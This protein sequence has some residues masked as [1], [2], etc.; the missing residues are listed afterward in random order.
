MKNNNKRVKLVAI[1]VAM[2]L[3]AQC[4]MADGTAIPISDWSSLN[5]ALKQSTAVDYIQLGDNITAGDSIKLGS[6]YS[7]DITFD[8]NGHSLTSSVNN[9]VWDIQSAT[10]LTIKNTTIENITSK[11][12]GGSIYNEG[13]LVAEN[14]TFSNNKASSYFGGAVANMADATFNGSMTFRGNSSAYSEN[15]FGGALLNIGVINFNTG[16]GEV[17]DFNG[18]YASYGGAIYNG[19]GL[20]VV[21]D[22]KFE[23]NTGR[24]EFNKN[25]TYRFENNNAIMGGAIYNAGRMTIAGNVTFKNNKALATVVGANNQRKGGGALYNDAG[26]LTLNGTRDDDGNASIVFEGNSAGPGTTPSDNSQH[27]GGALYVEGKDDSPAY[28]NIISTDFKNNTTTT[29]GGAIYFDKRVDFNIEDSRFIQNGLVG[30]NISYDGWGGAIGLGSGDIKGFI[31]NSVFQE[32]FSSSSGGVIASNTALT[33]VNS[34]FIGNTA[35]N[36]AGAISWDPHYGADGKY[37]KII[38]DGGDTFFGGNKVTG[39]STPAGTT[40][41]SQEGLYIGNY[42]TADTTGPDG[43]DSKVFFNAGN[44]G[45]LIFN[46]V[47]NAK[48][49]YYEDKLDKFKNEKINYNIQLN[50]SDVEYGRLEAESSNSIPNSAPTDGMIIFNNTVKGANLVLHNGTLAFHKEN[51]LDGYVGDNLE[52]YFSDGAKITLKGGTLDLSN[53]IIEGSDNHKKNRF[54]PDSIDVLGNANLRLDV[55]LGNGTGSIDYIDSTIQSSNGQGKLVIDKLLFNTDMPSSANLG[56]SFTLQFVKENKLGLDDITLANSLQTII[57]SH[58]GYSLKLDQ[59]GRKEDETLTEKNALKVT[60]VVS[61]GGLPVAVSIG[62]DEALAGEKTYV[63]NATDDEVIGLPPTSPDEENKSWYKGYQVKTENM[64]VAEDRYTSNILKGEFLEINGNGKNVIAA[65]D[66]IVGMVLDVDTYY[67]ESINIQNQKLII[68]D[69]KKSDGT[70]WNGFNTAIINKGGTVNLNNSIFSENHSTG[71]AYNDVS[72]KENGNVIAG[73]PYSKDGNGGAIQNLNR[74]KDGTTITSGELNVTNTSFTNNTATGDGGAIY[75][76]DGATT[77][78]TATGSNTVEFTGNKAGGV[79]NDIYNAG[80]LNLVTSA[81]GKIVFNGGISG[82]NGVM[83]IGT[84]AQNLGSVVMNGTIADQ[85]VNLNSGTLQI[86]TVANAF[87]NSNLTFNGGT[88]NSQNG[89]I[90]NMVVGNLN[91]NSNSN[92]LFDID[93]S[94]DNLS[95]NIQFTTKEGDGTLNVGTLYITGTLSDGTTSY[96]S[97]FLRGTDA[98]KIKTDYKGAGTTAVGDTAYSIEVRNNKVLISKVGASGGFVYDVVDENMG[99]HQVS[100]ADNGKIGDWIPGVG[101]Q[102]RGNIFRIYG[103]GADTDIIKSEKNILGIEVGLDEVQEQSQRLTIEDV[104]SYGGFNSAVINRGGEVF[105]NGVNFVENNASEK[106]GNLGYGGAIYNDHGVVNIGVSTSGATTFQKNNATR[107]GGAIYNNDELDI[108]TALAGNTILFT[109]NKA[110]GVANDIY[111][112]ETGKINIFGAGSVQFDSGIAGIGYIESSAN[113][114]LNS[115]NSKFGGRFAQTSGTTTVT[116]GAKFFDGQSTISGGQLNWNTKEDLSKGSLIV[117][118]GA[119]LIVGDGSNEAQLSIKGSSDITNADVTINNNANLSLVNK[120]MTIGNISGNGTLTADNSTLIYDQNSGVTKGFASINN[121]TVTVN[122][123]ENSNVDSIIGAIVNGSNVGLTLNFEDLTTSKDITLNLISEEAGADISNLNTS[124]D[125][126]I[127]GKLT[128]NA[129]I[130]TNSGTLT[131]SGTTENNYELV[132]NTN[133]TLNIDGIFTGKQTATITNNGT[134]NVT[135]DASGFGGKLD[136]YGDVIVE[137]SSYLFGGEK[138][139]HTGTLTINAGSI[140][141]RDVVLGSDA[142]GAKLI[143]TIS[144]NST[145]NKIDDSVFKFADGTLG[146]E[147]SFKSAS[148]TTANIELS[149]VDNGQENTISID[150]ANVTL[151]DKDYTGGTIYN[152]DNSNIKLGSD[153][154][155]V[156]DYKFSNV[157]GSDN[158]LSFNVIIADVAGAT[159]GSKYL[160][161]D[162]ITIGNGGQSFKFG[163][164]YISGEE[165]GWDGIYS[166]KDGDVLTGATFSDN[167]ASN[168]QDGKVDKLATGA[169]TSWIYDISKTN[170][171][172]SIQ[173]KI[174]SAADENTLYKMNHKT[175]G[176]RFFQFSDDGSNKEQTY[177]I[178]QSLDE[179][180][181]GDFTVKGYDK[182]KCTISGAF[183]DKTTGQETGRGSFFDI[184]KDD[185][186]LTIH[187]VTLANASKA[188]SGSV[189]N[190]ESTVSKVTIDNVNIISSSSSTDGGAIYNNG[191]LNISNT[192]FT[193]NS[194]GTQKGGAIYNDGTMNL[195][196]VTLDAP[197]ENATNDIYQ[198]ANGKTYFVGGENTINSSISGEGTIENTNSKLVLNG[199]NSKYT[200]TYT[201]N[202]GQTDVNEGS[203]FFG[204]ETTITNGVLNWNTMNDYDGVIKAEGG[205][206]NIGNNNDAELTLNTGSVVKKDAFVNIAKAGSIYLNGGSLTLDDKDKWQGDIFIGDENTVGS[207]TLTIDGLTSNGTIAANG[208]TIDIISGRLTASAGDMIKEATTVKIKDDALLTVSGGDVTLGTTTDWASKGGV[209]LTDGT[210]T[211]KDFTSS[212]GIFQATNG[213]LNIIENSTFTVGKDSFINSDVE[214]NIDSNSNL[215]ITDNGKVNINDNDTW[216]GTISLDGGTLNYGMTANGNT[217]NN[218]TLNAKTG[219]LNLLDGSYMDIQTPSKIESAVAVDIQRGATINIRNGAELNLDSNDRW[220]GLITNE[221]SGVLKTDNVDNSTYGGMLQQNRGTSIFDNNSNIYIDGKDSYIRGGTLGITNGSTLHVGSG[222]TDNH[223]FVSD[224]N[225]TNNSTLSAMNG[226][227]NRYQITN[228]M[229]VEGKNNVSIDIDGRNKVGDTFIINNLT[230]N[231]NGTLNVSDFNF[232][233]LAPID[234]QF[235]IRVFDSNSIADTVDFSSTNKE[236]LTPIGY[237]NLQSAGG[238]WYTSNMTRYNPQVFRGQVATLASFNNQLMIDDMLLNHVTLDS[239]R[240]LAQGKNANTYASTLPQFAPYQYK[241]EDGGLWY[242]SYVNFENLSLTQG[243]KVGNNSYGSLVGADFPI[244]KL[245]HGWRLMPTAYIGYNG[246][247]QTFNGV[248]MYQNGGQGGLMGTFMK[249]DFIGSIVAYGGGYNNE[250][251]VE[252]NT[253]RTGNW[254]AGTAAKLAYNFHP[255]KHFTIQPTAFMSYNIFGRQNWGT[256]FGSMSMNS[257]LL[258]GINVAPGMNFIYARETWSVYATFQYMYN[259]NEQVGGR[260]GNVDLAS[261]KMEHGYIQYGV[262]VTKTWKDRLNSFFQIVF[263]NGGRTGVGFQLGLNYT[264]DWFN[265]KSNKAPKANAKQIKKSSTSNKKSQEIKEFQHVGSKTVLKSLSMK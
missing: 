103:K 210:L 49:D 140:E 175:E 154:T 9:V 181:S 229:T 84:S 245:K 71:G 75:N 153:N 102:L 183:V 44:S 68:N 83:N 69:V 126:T 234:R 112:T 256:D 243:L 39:G 150:G 135:K 211:V 190:N 244:I 98:D 149:K 251:S 193:G 82:N 163:D 264:F 200:G 50:S 18:N 81:D 172:Q 21:K 199:D 208:G 213:E 4:A 167:P 119:K 136:S 220:A 41:P 58:A 151:V 32:N 125:V 155:T 37:L 3:S 182:D 222:V 60:K 207:G 197:T 55:T 259:I 54:N 166:T 107:D 221:T 252:G 215:Q 128:N 188:T 109:G 263:R 42:S 124:G 204:G 158:K 159:D 242:K 36:S 189:V 144:D 19:R 31:N 6:G 33:I 209:L 227:L 43:N 254:F 122:G 141:Y 17:V 191:I 131:L 157:T 105:A 253:D 66:S 206:I 262:G 173:M 74:V 250:M 110:G 176:T 65:K 15:S 134:I 170:N 205:L 104:K 216:G 12:W 45:S 117:K 169:T 79:D 29:H 138:N 34:K 13:S 115:D 187:D 129:G 257:G 241:K 161:T 8:G 121:S 77:N 51:S 97:E 123:T 231:T 130:V 11:G 94:Q 116:N 56:D 106:D 186:N 30:N 88:L 91:I 139:I 127:S 28:V 260:A 224:L 145:V 70:G 185:I 232:V 225:M 171:N 57:T 87:D 249:N 5:S 25:G 233:G 63:Y 203:K 217:A 1:S 24:I 7:N 38:A 142:Q 162:K 236:I 143:H 78:I 35:K 261:V 14:M 23:N 246:A 178:G 76:A 152:F 198:G 86:G 133:S 148:G 93:L 100:A 46:D 235:K 192:K 47:F 80:I 62:Q 72:H 194:S 96:S 202:S 147:A 164:I 73:T 64:K 113:V 48:G 2:L 67:P 177:N 52:N 132:N 165:N 230:S 101:N 85:T 10:K 61:S 265:P 214:T 118:E 99:G 59:Y 201:Q 237:Y 111:N 16:S 53:N 114:I 219:N 27:L 247:H 240:L 195:G 108:N 248:G 146:S 212:N 218:G 40:S 179:T 22:N 120:S 92:F 255:T 95:D 174:N 156:G 223:F 184:K 238:G 20:A 226:V 239:E 180:L 258:N 137:N 89:Q 168:F 196:G 90:D 160:Q 26:N 228:D